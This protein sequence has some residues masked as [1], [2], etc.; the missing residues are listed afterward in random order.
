MFP[1]SIRTDLIACLKS[2]I[3]GRS[4]VA[5][6]NNST[7]SITL[8][9][10]KNTMSVLRTVSRISTLSQRSMMSLRQYSDGAVNNAGGGMGYVVTLWFG[11]IC[12]KLIWI[13]SYSKREKAAEGNT[14][15]WH[16]R[17]TSWFVETSIRSVFAYQRTGNAEET[18]GN[19]TSWWVWPLYSWILWLSL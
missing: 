5:W 16:P 13:L 9:R 12:V 7:L 17:D 3:V 6:E 11:F 14:S 18:K 15:F 2:D 19:G 10:T 1:R 8:T 4:E